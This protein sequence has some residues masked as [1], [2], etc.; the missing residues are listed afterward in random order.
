MTCEQGLLRLL[1]GGARSWSATALC[2]MQVL[3]RTEQKANET[4][5]DTLELKTGE[6]I[7]VLNGACMQTEIKDNFPIKIGK[8]RNKNLEVLRDNK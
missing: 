3:P 4:G 1:W 2:T 7:K 6:K 8:M 5:M